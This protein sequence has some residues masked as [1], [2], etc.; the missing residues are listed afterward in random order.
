M[1]K[2]ELVDF[3]AQQTGTYKKDAKAAVDAVL[4]GIERGLLADG[5]VTLVG[6]GNF[7]TKQRAPRVARNPQ[8]GA[9]VNVPAK[10]VPTFKPSQ[11]LK[12]AVD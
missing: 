10:T 8:T 4:E 7:L 2:A 9:T 3:V 6:F 11:Q 1:N 12:D 5:K